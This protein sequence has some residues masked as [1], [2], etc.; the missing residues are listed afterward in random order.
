MKT[1][2]APADMIEDQLLVTVHHLVDSVAERD[3]NELRDLSQ[4]LT[5]S[6]MARIFS[7][8]DEGHPLTLPDMMA[9][10]LRRL[11][12][13]SEWDDY[14]EVLAQWEEAQRDGEE[15]LT[16]RELEKLGL[17]LILGTSLIR[18]SEP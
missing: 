10:K 4:S 17:G 11:F 13:G 18:R 2:N 1:H 5:A 15:P 16:S 7:E 9:T 3:G 12:S 8:I 14:M 6:E